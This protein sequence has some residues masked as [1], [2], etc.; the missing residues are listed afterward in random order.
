MKMI[1]FCKPSVVKF[2]LLNK[3]IIN[4]QSEN[5]KNIAFIAMK[6][7]RIDNIN[8]IKPTKEFM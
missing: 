6:E 1:K 7:N 2:I 5:L 4:Y 3:E 8:V